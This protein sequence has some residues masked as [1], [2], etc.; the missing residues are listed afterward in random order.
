[1][2]YH[3]EGD[4][5][6]MADEY[7]MEDVED[8]MDDVIVNRETD[9]LE[10]DG[11]EYDYSV[12]DVLFLL[13]FDLCCF[14]DMDMMFI[15]IF[16]IC[17]MIAHLQFVVF[18]VCLSPTRM[19]HQL[20]VNYVYSYAYIC[21]SNIVVMLQSSKVVDTTAAHARR[22]QDIQGIPWDSLSITRERYRQTRLEQY[23]NYENIPHSG[24]KSGKVA[25]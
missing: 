2:C 11:D 4:A 13:S 1:M 16:C 25:I 9:D 7:E 24:E 23:K 12:S 17:I 15:S 6:Y 22:G 3:Q 20:N 18:S 10:S 19:I 8:D 21:R 5:E 14:M